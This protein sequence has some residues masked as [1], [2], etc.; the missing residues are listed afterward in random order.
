M[1]E[2][3]DEAVF[4]VDDAFGELDDGVLFARFVGDVVAVAVDSSPCCTA[5][6]CLEGFAPND[7]HTACFLGHVL[8]LAAGDCIVE[9]FE[10]FIRIS[11]LLVIER[12]LAREYGFLMLDF[13]FLLR[14]LA[15]RL[16]R[17]GHLL[18]RT[19]SRHDIK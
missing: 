2:G 5:G 18:D 9:C 15:G 3:V 19:A 4:I 1:G 17:L 10:E 11:S 12:L 14:R 6:G 8:D 7:L 16:G 13:G